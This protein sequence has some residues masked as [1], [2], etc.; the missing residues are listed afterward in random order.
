MRSISLTI[1][2]VFCLL[3]SIAFGNEKQD[4][5]EALPF[6]YERCPCKASLGDQATLDVPKGY[7]FVNKE[8]VN[9][10]LEYS[11]NFP[12]GDELGIVFPED[13]NF[14][15]IYSFQ[16]VGYVKDDEKSDLDAD[17]LLKSMTE[18]T[19]AANEERRKRGWNTLKVIGW[20]QAPHYDGASNNLEWGTIAQ[21]ES[22]SRSVNYNSRYLGRRGVMSVNLVTSPE[23]TAKNV[24]ALRTIS[25]GF[26]YTPTNRYTAFVK[27]DKV[28]EY[29]L[30]ALI[31]GGATAA[32]AKGG[33]LKSLFKFAAAFWKIILLAIAGLGSAIVKLFRRKRES[34][35][36]SGQDLE[37]AIPDERS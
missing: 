8:N 28:A 30:T 34:Q 24:A 6:E 9:K 14:F 29:G 12:E 4:T 19:E 36:A 16:N 37:P 26:D 18:A 10:F 32:A 13:F 1:A 31:L 21:S 27:G 17:A 33:L 11:E 7:L 5:A 23:D 15:I 20:H 2:G 22:G 3:S 35:D 25:T